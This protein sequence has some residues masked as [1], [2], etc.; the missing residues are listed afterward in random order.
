[1]EV[2]RESEISE[3]V[4]QF[5]SAWKQIVQ[6]LPEA[7]CTDNSGLSIRWA[8]HVFFFWNAI[9][10]DRPIADADALRSR[11]RSALNYMPTKRYSGLIWIFEELLGDSAKEKLPIIL[12][13]EGLEAA[14]PLTGMAGEIFPLQT[15]PHP[16]LRIERVT[17]E[18]MLREYAEIN[19]EAY[20]LPLEWG[21]SALEPK[22]FIDEGYTY[23]GY[24]NDRAVSAAAT[25]V[26]EGCLFLALVATRPDARGKGY[27]EAIVRHSLQKAHEA[28][29]LTRTILH[30]TDAGHPVYKRIG[31]HD[32][33]RVMAYKLSA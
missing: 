6:D 3:S 16:S 33:A 24:E 26:N 32:T 18:T 5:T 11:L 31:Y 2:V 21:H 4:E 14:M 20:G 17:D 7:D 29:G 23:L 27:G 19:C 28:T 22:L 8:D 13:E 10:L 1:M 30:A 12:K 9:F 25:F 15:P